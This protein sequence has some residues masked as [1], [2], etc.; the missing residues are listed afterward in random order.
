M[1]ADDD[2]LLDFMCAGARGYLLEGPENDEIARAVLT[3]A[4]GGHKS[5]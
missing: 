1:H 3:V 4:A 2:T 5:S